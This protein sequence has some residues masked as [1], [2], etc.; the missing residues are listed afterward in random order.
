[1][2][3]FSFCKMSQCRPTFF[4]VKHKTAH[5]YAAKKVLFR[6]TQR[7]VQY[8]KPCDTVVLTNHI[9]N[10]SLLFGGESV[11]SSSTVWFTFSPAKYK[12]CEH[13]VFYWYAVLQY[14]RQIDFVPVL[15]P[16]VS[17]DGSNCEAAE[18]RLDPLASLPHAQTMVEHGLPRSTTAAQIS[19]E[20]TILLLLSPPPPPSSPCPSHPLPPPPPPPRWQRCV[21]V[22]LKCSCTPRPARPNLQSL[23]LDRDR[24][25]DGHWLGVLMR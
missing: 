4:I 12:Y 9:Y 13:N 7:T 10:F 18:V 3:H 20:M 1:M 22:L 25:G 14:T 21:W 24:T 23:T 11:C 8:C 15:H 17:N 16:E 19:L 6:Y 5:K 2:S